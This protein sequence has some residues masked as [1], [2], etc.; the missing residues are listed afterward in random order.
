MRHG[1]VRGGHTPLSLSPLPLPPSS[2]PLQHFEKLV[3]E[4]EKGLEV[5]LGAYDARAGDGGQEGGDTGG[6]RGRVGMG[7]SMRAL[8]CSSVC[9]NDFLNSCLR[10]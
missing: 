4:F 3:N 8:A 1:A 10:V 6:R 7:R 9:N 5:A 2:Y